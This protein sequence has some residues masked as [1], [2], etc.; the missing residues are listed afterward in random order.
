MAKAK[1]SNRV[2]LPP[3]KRQSS[4]STSFRLRGFADF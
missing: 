1:K 4:S 3:E 2:I